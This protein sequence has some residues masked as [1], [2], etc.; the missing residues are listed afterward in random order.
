MSTTATPTTTLT[1]EGVMEKLEPQPKHCD[2]YIRDKSFPMCLRIFLLHHRVPASWR[3]K[4]MDRS[5]TSP[6]WKI[7]VCFATMPAHRGPGGGKKKASR[8]RLTMASRFG[9]VG[10]TKDLDQESGY[11]ARVAVEQLTDFSEVP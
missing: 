7:P 5:E 6:K 11:Q 1:E 3:F 9:D 4:W 2:D 8:V 10:V